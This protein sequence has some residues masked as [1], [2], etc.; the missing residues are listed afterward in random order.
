MCSQTCE[1]SN[2]C[3][4]GIIQRR[5]IV[6]YSIQSTLK[7]IVVV[8]F[9]RQFLRCIAY[10]RNVFLFHISRRYIRR[11]WYFFATIDIVLDF[12]ILCML[13]YQYYNRNSRA[14][15]GQKKDFRFSVIYVLGC[16]TERRTLSEIFR[17]EIVI[18]V[19]IDIQC[20]RRVWIF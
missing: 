20:G 1:G 17:L 19:L 4:F 10:V 6:K 15:N 11:S 5:P 8:Q 13:V 14:Q 16:E 18:K 2:K 7:K 12:V 9:C 3:T